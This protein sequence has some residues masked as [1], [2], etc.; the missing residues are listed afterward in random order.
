MQWHVSDVWCG[1]PGRPI[2][3]I[4]RSAVTTILHN[5][6][7][8]SVSVK[9]FLK[10]GQYLISDHK[11]LLCYFYTT[12]YIVRSLTTWTAGSSDCIR[13][14]SKLLQQQV[15]RS[16]R[17][18][19]RSELLHRLQWLR[20]WLLSQ[21]CSWN[22]VEKILPPRHSVWIQPVFLIGAR[23]PR[24]RQQNTV[25]AFAQSITITQYYNRQ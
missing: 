5:F 10:L 13:V 14:C 12:P 23:L 19:E 24:N 16:L 22:K 4:R 17:T 21:M 8:M 15:R 6:I 9:A 2:R 11:N 18:S 25:D 1:L 7:M 20:T 3:G